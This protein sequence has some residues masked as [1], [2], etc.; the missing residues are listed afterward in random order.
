MIEVTKLSYNSTGEICPRTHKCSSKQ[1]RYGSP[2]PRER[3][4]DPR[5]ASESQ[6]GLPYAPNGSILTMRPMPSGGF[7]VQGVI[8]LEV[9]REAQRYERAAVCSSSVPAVELG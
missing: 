3:C 4:V 9:E 7:P 6:C 1:A 2:M 8:R 5:A